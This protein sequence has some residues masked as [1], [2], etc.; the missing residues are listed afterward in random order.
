MQCISELNSKVKVRNSHTENDKGNAKF[1]K[2]SISCFYVN[3]RSIVN[4]LDE[5]ALY[6]DEEKPD[7]IGLTKTWLIEDISNHE[8]GFEGYTY[9]E[10]IEI[11]E[12]K[13][14]EEV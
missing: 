12:L 4:K 2:N 1:H 11:V 6:I 8:I 9:L 7:I 10:R 3:T 5:I 13:V 14:E